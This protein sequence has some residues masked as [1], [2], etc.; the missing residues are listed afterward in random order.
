M[1]FGESSFSFSTNYVCV[2]QY[3]K[4][5]KQRSTYTVTRAFEAKSAI[6]AAEIVEALT[7]ATR[8]E[9]LADTFTWFDD[10]FKSQAA[11]T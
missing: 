1:Q 8:P 7:A 4:Q 11:G 9:D 3:D 6:W 5:G 10:W 2:L